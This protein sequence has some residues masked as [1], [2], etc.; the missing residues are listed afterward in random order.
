MPEYNKLV[1]DRIPEIIKR[2]GKELVIR[3]AEEQEYE[4]A[5]TRKLHEEVAEFLES[6]SAEEAADVLEV[7]LA[8]CAHKDIDTSEFE[9]TRQKK[10]EERGG[11]KDRIIL[12]RTGD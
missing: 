10:A 1:R 2:D 5:L 7:L 8:I 3:T 4:E 11:F 12:E 6:P 9:Q